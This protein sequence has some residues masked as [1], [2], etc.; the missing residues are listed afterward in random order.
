MLPTGPDFESFYSL[1]STEM[2]RG[3]AAAFIGAGLSIPGGYSSWKALL[4][5][6]ADELKLDIE[7][8]VDLI[9]LAQFIVKHI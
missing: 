7:R 2:E 8:E 5:P 3:V 6:I 1:F 4:R 9:S